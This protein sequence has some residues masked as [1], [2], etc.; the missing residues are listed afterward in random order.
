MNSTSVIN[1]PFILNYVSSY[2]TPTDNQKFDNAIKPLTKSYSQT[3]IL[4]RG[5]VQSG[6]TAKIM[7]YIKEQQNPK[8]PVILHIQNSLSMLSQYEKTLKANNIKFHSISNQNYRSILSF[9]KYDFSS[10]NQP[11]V[12][13]LM[14]NVYRKSII[15]DVIQITG[16][17]KYT[18]IIDESDLYFKEL[19]YDKLYTKANTVIHVTA[20]PYLKDY[21][22]YF[23][24]VI[25][26]IPNSNYVGLS[27]VKTKFYEHVELDK[28]NDTCLKIIKEDFLQE[29]IGMM[30]INIHHT[31]NDMHKLACLLMNKL[32][33]Y[34]I[35]IILLSTESKLYYDNK[36]S[37]IKNCSVSKI[38]TMFENY[39]N[40]ILIAHRLASRGINYSNLSYT[41][42]ITHQI[43]TFGTSKTSFL[44]K[45]RIFGNKHIDHPDSTMYIFNSSQ[46]E[47][48]SLVLST[49]K[50]DN[51]K[52]L[53]SK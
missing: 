39:P 29:F 20:T 18:L 12:M 30:L 23:D 9:L 50:L 3:Q 53:K 27:Q 32:Y 48:D 35:P 49:E 2:L 47:Y 42:S 8:L 40:V 13:L 33:V 43:T 7:E 26:V 36:I 19:R 14:S 21:R 16:L 1:N 10:T 45:S 28:Y 31:I 6:K 17:K 52:L 22:N 38:I 25:E 51:S 4:I 24:R 15:N 5:Q 41:R 34:D 46:D 37:Y 11:Y 44:Q